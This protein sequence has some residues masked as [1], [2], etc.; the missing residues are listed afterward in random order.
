M[1]VQMSKNHDAFLPSTSV[2]KDLMIFRQN[3]K[4][5]AIVTMPT[6]LKADNPT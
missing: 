4:I 6:L 5:S 3:L 1:N 2:K